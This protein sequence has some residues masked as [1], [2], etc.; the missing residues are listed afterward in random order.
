MKLALQIAKTS[1]C[2]HESFWDRLLVIVVLEI[3]SLK[4]VI[5]GSKGEDVKKATAL[6]VPAPFSF[7]PFL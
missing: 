7:H 1:F 4:R 3:E 6:R 5:A 2:L